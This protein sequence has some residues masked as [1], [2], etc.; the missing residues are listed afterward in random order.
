LSKA[1]SYNYAAT[2]N[3]GVD[4][5]RRDSFVACL[6]FIRNIKLLQSTPPSWKA[7]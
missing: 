4:G 5:S 2:V 6:Q 7:T 3:S 1:S